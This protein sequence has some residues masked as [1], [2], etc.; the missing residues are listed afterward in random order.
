MHFHLP[1][2]LHGWRQFVGEVGIIVIGVLIALGAEQIVD[3]LHDRS[4]AAE[5]RAAIRAEIGTDLAA[6]VR[7][8]Q[9]E[10]C[11]E[12]K[13]DEIRALLAQW[14][15]TGRFK[16]PQWVGAAPGTPIAL[17]RYDAA[18]SAGRMAI[19]GSD[20]QY[21]LG[22]V[23]VGLRSFLEIENSERQ[24]WGRLRALQAGPDALSALDRAQ[25]RLAL[26]DAATLD[27]AARTSLEQQLPRAK[28]FGFAP[29]F[30]IFRTMLRRAVKGGNATP[31]I[32]FP[33]D[34]PR[35]IA[36]HNLATQIPL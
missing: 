28:E 1:K 30:T 12:R 2:P 22:V 10:S 36:E 33:I 16:T 31:S 7:R 14:S 29:D 34:T 35:A 24:P 6:L 9:Y 26:Q 32:C 23:A 27:Y 8:K 15:E 20:E 13:L 25:I 4:M 5:T 17:V 18:V 19:L 3:K 21:R 11:V